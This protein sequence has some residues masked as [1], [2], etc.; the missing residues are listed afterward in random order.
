MAQL[1]RYFPQQ[2]FVFET[3]STVYYSEVFDVSE[4]TSLLLEARLHGTSATPVT[5]TVAIEETSDPTLANWDLPPL[6]TGTMDDAT[7]RVR[8][9]APAGGGAPLRFVR[10]KLS[11]NAVCDATISV[12]G[13]AS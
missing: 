1:M 3:T 12:E 7:T 5:F 6:A 11:T 13:G 9:I 10:V 2:T 4:Y 8:K